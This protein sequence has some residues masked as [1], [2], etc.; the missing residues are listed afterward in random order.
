MGFEFVEVDARTEQEHAAVPVPAAFGEILLGS[1]QAGLL[2]K[3]RHLHRATAVR[4]GTCSYVPVARCRV[5]WGDPEYDDAAP[6]GE[7]DAALHYR[8]KRGLVGD[9]MV[10]GKNEE[11]RIRTIPG[12]RNCD[13]RRRRCGVT[14]GRLEYHATDLFAAIQA[15]IGHDGLVFV[16]ADHQGSLATKA[17]ESRQ[18]LLEQAG[19]AGEAPVALSGVRLT[20]RR[21]GHLC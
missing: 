17:A 16:V 4:T 11:H 13:D 1:R 2:G 6:L 21:C 14:R 5:C 15:L 3:R 9:E 8:R 7:W 18:R 10:G 19:L 12:R 20:C